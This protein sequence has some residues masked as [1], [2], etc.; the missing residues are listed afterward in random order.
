MP[1]VTAGDAGP[2][3]MVT[4][5]GWIEAP[6]NPFCRTSKPW[7]DA[8]EAGKV[9]TPA[10]PRSMEKYSEASSA[11]I[12]PATMRLITGRRM[13]PLL[14]R[15]QKPPGRPVAPVLCRKGTRRAF[16]RSPIAP[17][18]AGS[19]VSAASRAVKTATM[20]PRAM[21]W[22]RVDGT[23]NR[24]PRARMT[25]RALNSTERVAVEADRPIAST[26]SRPAALSSL[27]RETTN[28]E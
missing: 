4:S 16:T 12:P 22:K 6:G 23:R 5:T 28:S 20:A 7:R 19:R 25:A 17:R 2:P 1:W 10:E 8:M 14:T 21:L 26:L 18:R 11:S 9:S 15:S 24:P 13:T 3:A 27:Y